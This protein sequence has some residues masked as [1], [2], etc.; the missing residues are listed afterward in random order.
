M[1]LPSLVAFML[2]AACL[3]P[4][5]TVPAPAQ[6]T[7]SADS[8]K[9]EETKALLACGQMVVDQL[10]ALKIPADRGLRFQG[11]VSQATALCRGGDQALQFRA[12]PWVD[13]AN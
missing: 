9:A 7:P 11:K 3:V 8:G 13:W 5:Q 1:K 6:G 12:T 4:A 10:G 2:A